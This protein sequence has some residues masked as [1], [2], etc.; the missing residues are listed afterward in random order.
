MTGN[1]STHLQQTQKGADAVCVGERICDR[2][3]SGVS[4]STLVNETAA[5]KLH[6]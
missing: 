5:S 4:L 1:S 6:N 2:N 3:G